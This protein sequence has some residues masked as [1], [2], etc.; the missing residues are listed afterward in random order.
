M[1]QA[2][3][4][5]TTFEA[6]QGGP[7][8]LSAD[9]RSPSFWFNNSEKVNAVDLVKYFS[10]FAAEIPT[11]THKEESAVELYPWLTQQAATI[12][13]NRFTPVEKAILVGR[14]GLPDEISLI[15]CRVL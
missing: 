7:V 15:K 4:V 14:S 1:Y 11:H 12:N 9:I 2:A 10:S 6:E 3:G 5:S 13:Q 8:L